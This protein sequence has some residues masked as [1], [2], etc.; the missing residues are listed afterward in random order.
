[1]DIGQ[2]VKEL[3]KEKNLNQEAL[4]KLVGLTQ[5]KVSDIEKG[6]KV[7]FTTDLLVRLAAAL[8]TT[9]EYLVDGRGLKK[10][11]SQEEINAAIQDAKQLKSKMTEEEVIQHLAQENK[12]KEEIIN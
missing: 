11:L 6:I 7:V 2:R 5:G 12:K 1:M 9:V 10:F 3:R 4:G 8:N